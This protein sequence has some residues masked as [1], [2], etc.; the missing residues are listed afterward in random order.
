MKR[1]AVSLLPKADSVWK[2]KHLLRWD[3]LNSRADARIKVSCQPGASPAGHLQG[4]GLRSSFSP[5]LQLGAG[6]FSLGARTD[7]LHLP[8]PRAAVSGTPFSGPA[9]R[10][11]RVWPPYGASSC[12]F[13]GPFN[14]RC[15]T[16]PPIPPTHGPQ[17][18]GNHK[19]QHCHRASGFPSKP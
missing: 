11:E 1:P 9:R 8:R 10:A 19:P 18:P 17:V 3:L 16:T 7:T 5:W 13:R 4:Q 15:Q 14:T 2:S 12:P 6:P